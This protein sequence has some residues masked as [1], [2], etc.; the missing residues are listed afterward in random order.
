ML[1]YHSITEHARVKPFIAQE[2][3]MVSILQGRLAAAHIE[4]LVQT[5]NLDSAAA[6]SSTRAAAAATP[7]VRRGHNSLWLAA[8]S[9]PQ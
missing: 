3:N 1:Y 8:K 9:Q 5:L 7:P 6:T 2:G 4:S